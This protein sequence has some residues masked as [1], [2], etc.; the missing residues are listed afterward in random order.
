[1]SI[2]SRIS[3]TKK[4]LYKPQC[5]PYNAL[6]FPQRSGGVTPQVV[7]LYG[8]SVRGPLFS[9]S[10]PDKSLLIA[11]QISYIYNF[12]QASISGALRYRA[13]MVQ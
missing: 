6:P 13:G 3:A 11:V 4:V 5:E 7:S 12:N 9:V 2:L 1:M 10:F 8:E